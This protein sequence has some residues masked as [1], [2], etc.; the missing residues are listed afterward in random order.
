MSA[1]YDPLK[2]EPPPQ[3]A[4]R[5]QALRDLGL[6]DA[7]PEEAFDRLT[8]L[9][10]LALRVPVSLLSFLEGERQFVKSAAGFSA[11]PWASERALPLSHSLCQEVV[12]RGAPLVVEDVAEHPLLSDHPAHSAFGVAAYL[13]VPLFT[14]DEAPIGSLCVIESE[15]RR[16]SLEELEILRDLAALAMDEIAARGDALGRA[17]AEAALQA[18]EEHHRV[19]TESASD[20]IITIDEGSTILYL[21]RAT[22]DI[23]GYAPGELLGQSLTCIMPE[24]LRHVHEA[25]LK[26]YLETGRRH[27]NWDAVEVPGLHQD[28]HEI[29]LEVSFGEHWQGGVHRFTGIL[30]DISERKRAET[31][32]RSSEERYRSLFESMDQG[33]CIIE[34]LFDKGKPS[35]YRFVETNPMFEKQTG[36]QHPAGK[37]VRELVP[38]LEAHWFETY[39][40]VALTGE[41]VRFV[42][43][44]EAMNRWFDVYAFRLGGRE[45]RK[46]AI[47]FT[48]ISERK[49]AEETLRRQ[50]EMLSLSHDAIFV[51][52]TDGGIET[53]NRGAAE[54]YGYSETEAFGRV[55]HDLLETVHPQPLPEVEAILREQGQWEGELKHRTKQGQELTVSSRHQLVRGADGLE[56]VLEINRDITESRRAE[57]ALQKSEERFRAI[58]NQVTAGIAQIDPSG[59]FVLVN[60]RYCDIVGYDPEALYQM[61]FQDLTHPEDLPRNLELLERL[62]GDGPGYVIEKRYLR[63]DGSH[64]WVSNG[65][66]AV[67]DASGRVQYITTVT[68]DITERKRAEEA[69]R[70]NEERTR[71]AVQ[72]TQLGTWRYDPETDL[73]HLDA[74]MRAIWGEPEDADTIPLPRVVARIHEEDRER[75]TGAIARALEPDSAGHYALEYRIVWDDGSERWVSANGQAQFGGE[76]ASWRAV[77]FVGTALD[78][79]ESRRAEEGLS[80]QKTLLESLTE[81]VLD[82]I[83]VVS[84]AGRLL[85]FNQHFLDIWNFPAEV[86]ASQSDEAALEWAAGQTVDPAAFLARVAA[87]YE[88]PDQEVHEEMSMRDGRVYERFGAPINDGDTRLAWVWTFRDITERKQAEATIEVA[89]RD[90][91]AAQHQLRA[92]V[93]NLPELAWWAQPDGHIDFYNRR[94][95]E[96]TG[97]TLEDMEGW[98]WQSVQHPEML[99]E[100]VARWQYALAT[101][102]LFEMEF[103]L[104]GRDG[105]YRW[106]LTRALP[107]R[108]A[109]GKIVR[110][111]GINTDIDAKR[112]AEAA[113]AEASE[114]LAEVNR[115]LEER[116]LDR[117]RAL[118]ASNQELAAFNYSVSHDLRAPLRGID[119][120]SQAL[121]E[122]YGD[123]LDATAAHYLGR[124]RGAAQR[125]GELIDDL[126]DLSRL[127]SNEMRFDLV[128]LSELTSSVAQ[129]LQSLEPERR[130]AVRVA[131]GLVTRGDRG[132]LKIALE[133]LLGNAW[134]FTSRRELAEIDFGRTPEGVYYLSDNGAGFNMEYASKLFAPFQRLHKP[135]EFEGTGIGLATVQRV[136]HRHG[137]KIWAES[138]ED[139]GTT[140]Y[141]TLPEGS[142][143]G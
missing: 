3:D 119:G 1:E 44:S 74:R 37:T 45:S 34:M 86:I 99:E 19:V 131:P 31:A 23:F 62:L 30:R 60:Q 83:L 21:N 75:V 87:V 113:A 63:K 35:D 56:R 94:W 49:G 72:L 77:G 136:I 48:D 47:L 104:R 135:N 132:M 68:I 115:T 98:G 123:K 42:D 12:A 36:L 50:S 53:W 142:S 80:Y 55:S 139:V 13:G 39:G 16:W 69:L 105:G 78:I 112:R 24:Y 20:A 82:A 38:N 5:L 107:L 125:M 81:T 76:G 90:A 18:S 17:R 88:Q 27:L 8:R 116:V 40:K 59:R 89:R 120:F 28:G 85:H 14:A 92:L 10:R 6:L 122:D 137:S 71:L 129:G 9:A 32:L 126:L 106:F 100:V 61:R 33:F 84:S 15:A 70:E 4:E 121:E 138:K 51:W 64:V 127:S 22:S 108:D 101:G 103:P 97:T 41:A 67:Q 133:N 26:R 66:R 58:F 114:R 124:V 93:D 111:I 118:E 29:A 141:F 102:E 79:T 11:E 140:F 65:V 117:T 134:K 2:P 110:W 7:L 95:Y 73:V 143:S 109:G 25:G 52:K 130:I 91:E 96:Y 46:V 128:D 54:L 43:G 57:E